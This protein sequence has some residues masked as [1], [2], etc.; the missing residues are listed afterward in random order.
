MNQVY[1]YSFV[2]RVI[3]ALT[4]LYKSRPKIS[5]QIVPIYDIRV[6]SHLNKLN[7]VVVFG[8]IVNLQFFRPKSHDMNMALRIIHEIR[9]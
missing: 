1:L 3:N 4:K 7:C 5:R 9:T 2:A 6:A 8:E